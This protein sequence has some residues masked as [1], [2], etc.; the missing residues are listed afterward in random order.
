[1]FR[2]AR[3]ELARRLQQGRRGL[4]ELLVIPIVALA[5]VGTGCA[6]AAPRWWADPRPTRHEL[7]ILLETDRAS[8]LSSDVLLLHQ[9]PD[10][11]VRAHLRPC[12]AFG[13][14]LRASIAGLI[15]VPGYR[16]PNLLGPGDPGPH[17]YDSALLSIARDGRVDPAF[18]RERNG[19]VYTCRRG[20]RISQADFPS[21][22]AI[23]REQALAE[24]GPRADRPD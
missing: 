20:R 6:A 21:V 22:V 1:V 12:C 17:R 14:E 10:I 9:I 2:R 16:V 4:R 15:P 18:G 23:I 19:L 7:E 11:P 3:A 24:L 5:L 13:S 8:T